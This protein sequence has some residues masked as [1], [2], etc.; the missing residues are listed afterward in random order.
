MS[1]CRT[2][3]KKFFSGTTKNWNDLTE[4]V[5][6]AATL[7]SFRSRLPKALPSESAPAPPVSGVDD[8]K[9]CAGRALPPVT[10]PVT[11]TVAGLAQSET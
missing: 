1:S 7:E 4:N 2:D 6:A 10:P 3:Y 11:P 9:G 5:A 8:G